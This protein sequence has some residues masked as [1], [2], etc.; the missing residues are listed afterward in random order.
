MYRYS[1]E[2]NQCKLK[3]ATDN[4]LHVLSFLESLLDAIHNFHNWR[5]TSKE[6]VNIQLD[7]ALLP[8]P[9]W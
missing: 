5:F 7:I 2:D 3:L 6:G 1:G 4:M 9:S 8:A